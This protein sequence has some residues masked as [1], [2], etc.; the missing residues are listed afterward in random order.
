MIS[1]KRR[2]YW[3][4]S[5]PLFFL[6]WLTI[7]A[8]FY[9]VIGISI[10]DIRSYAERFLEQ[11]HY[12]ISER[13]AR[14]E[15]VVSNLVLR[16]S[17][18]VFIS[19]DPFYLDKSFQIFL[20]KA[21]EPIRHFRRKD[22]L[23]VKYLDEVIRD[24]TSDLLSNIQA[25]AFE[26]SGNYWGRPI[27]EPL[28]IWYLPYYY[29]IDE[30]TQ[31]ITLV[32][33]YTF[34]DL[35]KSL[36]VDD[37]AVALLIIDADAYA[38][39][40]NQIQVAMSPHVKTMSVGH[41]ELAES[42]NVHELIHKWRKVLLI[43]S[44]DVVVPSISIGLELDFEDLFT[45]LN[46]FAS[47]GAVAVLVLTLVG[48]VLIR[49][50]SAV[51]AQPIAEFN[52]QLEIISN[53]NFDTRELPRQNFVEFQEISEVFDT[54]VKRL[55]HNV[56]LR[57]KEA[58]ESAALASELAIAGQIQQDFFP[59]DIDQLAAKNH[60]DIGAMLTPAKA[61]A[62]D[63]FYVLEQADGKLLMVIG[64]VSGKGIAAS[65]V[66]ADCVS[67]I[68]IHGVHHS[69]ATLISLMNTSLYEKFAKQS[70]FVTILCCSL[71]PDTGEITYC[72]A[73]HLAPILCNASG[74]I[75][76][77][78]VDR[79]M[80]L[81]FLKD[82]QYQQSTIRLEPLESLLLYTDG[83]EGTENQQT[84]AGWIPTS[85]GY[86]RNPVLDTANMATKL[87]CMTNRVI[88][89]QQGKLYD[90]ITLIGV[91]LSASQ[92]ESLVVRPL[93]QELSTAIHWLRAMTKRYSVPEAPANQLCVALDEWLANLLDHGG[94]VH[95]IIVAARV[96]ENQFEL[97]ISYDTSNLYNP[98]QHRVK[99]VDEHI[100]QQVG[101]LG[102]HIIQSIMDVIEFDSTGRW[103]RLKL[104]KELSQQ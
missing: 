68:Q 61:I 81:G 82:V 23:H 27:W 19:H 62:G 94:D 90:D 96:L 56:K 33:L 42:I 35:V 17:N 73:G 45:T 59:K 46:L 38:A 39:H 26:Q 24:G 31:L 41:I 80:A 103:A 16:P 21:G 77:L 30:T 70:M 83:L 58:E 86:F 67:C 32:P 11:S 34:Y 55:Q 15:D 101:G 20:L 54:L 104:I 12:Q 93:R 65:L 60:I 10:K 29:Q 79:Q 100:Q 6:F 76:V 1:L 85:T 8:C 49:K 91:N 95:D 57:Q 40:E 87:Q 36:N 64:D 84:D 102:I 28:P 18:E 3:T 72:N 48:L 69:P 51:F 97:V 98:L 78:P 88:G 25:Q 44:D 92:H 89:E 47:V 63:F 37:D 2:F 75:D 74:V 4:F 66:A 53:G 52:R 5:L 71:E 13:L 43:V 50:G 22:S 9:M 99:D 14:I 7:V